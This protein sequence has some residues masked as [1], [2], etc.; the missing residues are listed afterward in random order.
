[1]RV[2][3]WAQLL[4]RVPTDE[5]TRKVDELLGACYSWVSFEAKDRPTL[6]QDL[7]WPLSWQTALGKT[8]LVGKVNGGK[9]RPI[10]RMALTESG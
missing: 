2:H 9:T 5:P 10:P 8:F 3:Y 6:I 4:K 1:V 7:I